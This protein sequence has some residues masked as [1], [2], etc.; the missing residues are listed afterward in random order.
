M[1]SRKFGVIK[2]ILLIL[3]AFLIVLP[4]FIKDNDLTIFPGDK[5]FK[6]VVYTDDND[7]AG[8]AAQIAVIKDSAIIFNYTLQ[9]SLTKGMDPYAGFAMELKSNNA[10]IDISKYDYMNIDI[11]TKHGNSFIINFKTSIEGFTVLNDYHTYYVESIQVPVHFGSIQYKIALKDLKIPEWWWKE[12]G[13]VAANLPKNADRKKLFGIDFQNGSGFLNNVENQMVITK[14]S[15]SKDVTL[16]SFVLITCSILYII[17]MLIIFLLYKRKKINN[18]VLTYNKLEVKNHFSEES[19]R[20]AD[21]IGKNFH[22]SDLTV[23]QVAKDVGISS[24]RISTILQRA[25]NYTFKQY[26]N[27]IRIA[28]AK[29]LLKDTDRTVSE[30]GFAVG[31][32]NMT[33][34]NR[35]FKQDTC[36]SPSEFR[37]SFK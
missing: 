7:S 9:K 24:P 1:V 14:L 12:V 6:F 22:I 23:E 8:T 34:F 3:P 26:L 18:T 4:L 35:V 27:E 33:H 25:F 19:V 5:Q 20:I 31:Y 21:F 36:Q 17:L 29:R 11:R 2:L 16:L 37:D 28:E 15:F 10:F 30:I 13:P 32:N